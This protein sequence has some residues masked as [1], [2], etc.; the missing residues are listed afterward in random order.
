MGKL[1][2]LLKIFIIIIISCVALYFYA[3]TFIY[4][5]T[6]LNYIEKSCSGSSIDPYLILS[7]IKVESGFKPTAISSKEAKG[8][9][10]IRDSTYSEVSDMFTSRYDNSDIYDPEINIKIGVA[11][12]KKLLNKYYG[13]YY[14]ALL[15][16]NGGMGNVNSWISKGIIPKDLDEYIVPDIPFK[17][18]KD[19][20]RKVITTYNMYKFLYNL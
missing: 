19:Y 4:K 8:L 2:V 6:Y 7:I 10:Q 11:Y 3:K 5:T 13:N 1:K 15:A 18:T 9:M 16:Y 17:E 14:I 20:L 12:F